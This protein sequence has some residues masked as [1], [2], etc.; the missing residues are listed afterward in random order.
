MP[1]PESVRAFPALNVDHHQAL[2]CLE[3]ARTA[4]CDLGVSVWD[5]ACQLPNLRAMGVS[6]TIL[7]WLVACGLAEHR[8]ETTSWCQKHR[9][10][11][12]V[13]NLCF[14]E[15]SCFVI[16]AAAIALNLG[17]HSKKQ[18]RLG[19]PT[20]GGNGQLPHYDRARRTLFYCG[21]IIKQFRVPAANQ[22]LILSA[23]E[24]EGW[25]PHVDDPLPPAPEIEP[26]KRIHD[27]IYRL[28]TNQQTHL[29]LF[30]GDGQGNG[31]NWRQID[32]R[33]TAD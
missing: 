8:Q 20:K 5:F 33:S 29:L 7:R 3:E 13:S 31:V 27:A 6:E 21:H 4:A 10:F 12:T 2:T 30:L 17:S 1:N 28:N 9:T 19:L 22:E 32:G 26:K 25:P 11:T 23:F 14:T 18:P 24:E 15:S 16:S